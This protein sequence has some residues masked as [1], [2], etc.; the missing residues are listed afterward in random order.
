[1]IMEAI[2]PD[3]NMSNVFSED[4]GTVEVNSI[5]IKW[6]N[7]S[8]NP[9]GTY[10][11]DLTW[12]FSQGPGAA[13]MGPFWAV[14]HFNGQEKLYPIELFSL[15]NHHGCAKNIVIQELN[16]IYH[17]SI[18]ASETILTPCPKISLTFRTYS[19]LKAV[20]DGSELSIS[21][22]P[23]GDV[24]A[25]ELNLS[26]PTGGPSVR[27]RLD[28]YLRHQILP[29]A[30]IDYGDCWSLKI[31]IAA[32][33]GAISMG[34]VKEILT[35]YS[36]SVSL[37]EIGVTDGAVTVKS[38]LDDF[39]FQ[40]RDKLY[41]RY[42]LL[43][44]GSEHFLSGPYQLK[45]EQET[46]VYHSFSVEDKQL[47]SLLGEC[48]LA[49]YIGSGAALNKTRSQGNTAPLFTPELSLAYR[50]KGAVLSWE[51]RLCRG[52][53]LQVGNSS[54]TV[55]GNSLELADISEQ[56]DCSV[57]AA[58]LHANCTGPE[59]GRIPLF[60]PAYYPGKDN[61]L[62][63]YTEEFGKSLLTLKLP[64][65]LFVTPL[66][67]PVASPP[68][69][70]EK[71]EDGYYLTA[72]RQDQAAVKVVLPV[73]LKGLQ[74]A[75]ITA[76]GFYQLRQVIARAVCTEP[77][78]ML[79][80]LN[81]TERLS[82]RADLFPGSCLHVETEAYHQQTASASDDSG[83]IRG[84]SSDYWITLSKE[85]ERE[86]LEFDSN[87]DTVM[88]SWLKSEKEE[89]FPSIGGL[90]DL[91]CYDVRLPYARIL[92][93]GGFHASNRMGTMY[94]SDN[95]YITAASKNILLPSDYLTLEE[96]D[97]NY[98]VLRGRSAVTLN[99][100]VLFDGS[101]LLVPLG[102]T[103]GGLMRRFGYERGEVIGQGRPPLKRRVGTPGMGLM[104]IRLGWA[105]DETFADML[106]LLPGDVIER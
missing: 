25:G 27:K 56:M 11:I 72:E 69:T 95:I 55:Y 90:I 71:K 74:D 59:S 15:E 105:C 43:R 80:C 39:A 103:L 3:Y 20:Y 16:P 41:L 36:Q 46:M 47:F 44:D 13:Y 79:Y 42:A 78:N 7:V 77:G 75:G 94:K 17:V 102:T 62:T 8:V 100:S 73:F 104:E 14:L 30:G 66:E 58:A 32:Y 82:R 45:D 97:M 19:D 92:Y 28:A 37:R 76:S 29:L 96:G 57:S 51:N 91:F 35:M 86:T 49:V 67:E 5:E 40:N 81:G 21:F 38:E 64:G 6:V 34:P 18:T 88:G 12:E 24:K 60:T 50:G 31:T 98:I 99:I 23:A 89:P 85:G 70:L 101:P 2:M 4:D 48:E 52:F 54:Q 61:S 65:E 93:P 84:S 26:S 9:D 53:R 33:A 22:T 106:P 63:L 87:F 1:M 68:Y 10:Q 83:Y